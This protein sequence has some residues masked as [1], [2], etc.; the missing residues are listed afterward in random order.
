MDQK[1][2]QLEVRPASPDDVTIV[3]VR[4]TVRMYN[5]FETEL[6]DLGGSSSIHWGFFG[7]AFGAALAFGVTLLTVHLD[8]KLPSI[9]TGLFAVSALSTVYFLAMG[10]RDQLRARARIKQIRQRPAD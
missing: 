9:F 10:I 8:G 4:R 3:Y 7:V 6:S 5:V 1:Q 2:Q